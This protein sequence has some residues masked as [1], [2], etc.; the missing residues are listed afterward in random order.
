M[1]IGETVMQSP[2]S[3]GEPCLRQMGHSSEYMVL[4][5]NWRIFLAS[6]YKHWVPTGPLVRSQILLEKQDSAENHRDSQRFQIE[7]EL[8]G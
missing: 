3:V 2:S 6:V 4:L 8:G 7:P 1:F 5:R